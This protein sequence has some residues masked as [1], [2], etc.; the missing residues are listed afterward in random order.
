M[1]T[2]IDLLSIDST[3]ILTMLQ[4]IVENIV[5]ENKFENCCPDYIKLVLEANRAVV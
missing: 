1:K 4:D 3:P 5:V 2:S